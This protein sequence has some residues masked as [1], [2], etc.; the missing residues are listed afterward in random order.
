MYT[1][2]EIMSVPGMHVNYLR[3][4]SLHLRISSFAQQLHLADSRSS[5]SSSNSSSTDYAMKAIPAATATSDSATGTIPAT[6]AARPAAPDG[7]DAPDE[8]EAD[9]LGAAPPEPTA[10]ND[11]LVGVTAALPVWEPML[12][13]KKVDCAEVMTVWVELDEVSMYASE[14]GRPRQSM[15]DFMAYLPVE[16]AMGMMYP[17]ARSTDCW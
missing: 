5:S 13:W 8:P 10:E 3:P 1:D 2:V 15:I 4:S 7:V 17:T 14:R 6:P 16:M 12:G 11:A 9:P